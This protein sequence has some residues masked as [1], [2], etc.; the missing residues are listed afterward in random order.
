MA[1]GGRFATVRGEHHDR[2]ASVGRTDAVAGRPSVCGAV[3]VLRSR[4]AASVDG[5]HHGTSGNATRPCHRLVR[6]HGCV[7]FVPVHHPGGALR[8]PLPTRHLDAGVCVIRRLDV[9]PARFW[10]GRYL[11]R[12][13][14]RSRAVGRYLYSPLFMCSSVPTFA[15]YGG[16]PV[17]L[18]SV[19]R[20]RAVCDGASPVCPGPSDLW[21]PHNWSC[22]AAPLEARRSVLPCSVVLLHTSALRVR[23]LRVCDRGHIWHGRNASPPSCWRHGCSQVRALHTHEGM[24]T[25][26]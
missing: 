8:C 11:R 12:T 9:P 20:M 24:C 5:Q 19:Q 2:P 23:T 26:M 18:P 3:V 1:S 14:G 4:G 21:F 13:S 6:C 22:P 25:S 10:G 17:R 16:R 15:P 7:R